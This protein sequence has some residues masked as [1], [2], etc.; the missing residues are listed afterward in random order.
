MCALP[1]RTWSADEM[2]DHRTLRVALGL[3]SDVVGGRV[4]AM[5]DLFKLL[6]ISFI[7]HRGVME[8]F[9][10]DKA[11]PNLLLSSLGIGLLPKRS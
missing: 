8:V 10:C 1:R 7:T 5:A 3:V 4:K 6:G 2:I 9:P 11:N